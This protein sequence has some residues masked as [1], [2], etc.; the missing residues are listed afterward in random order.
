MN[1]P[2]CLTILRIF[3]VPLL[4]VVLLTRFPNWEFIGVAIF[5]SA[6]LTDWL[7]GHI[8]RRRRQIT[9]L[10]AWLDPVADKLLVGAAFIALVEMQL[11]P[12]WIVVII[13]GR[14]VTV[15]ALR[16]IALL[17]GFSIA[18][19]GLGKAK[20]AI[21]VVTITTLI[22][23][24]RSQMMER[25]GHAALWLAMALALISAFQY[26]RRFWIQVS[27][28]LEGAPGRHPLV[29][30]TERQKGNVSTHQ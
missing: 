6:A 22:L 18:V 23:G 10:G 25:F 28:P 16:N 4:V 7:D 19:S 17:R 15:T 8:A 20:M 26:F 12:A 5:L 21:E 3:L 13:V 29:G 2:N 11:A 30:L 24:E 14:E 9:A 1:L 27:V